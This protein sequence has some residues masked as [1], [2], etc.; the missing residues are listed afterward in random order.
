[1]SQHP[2]DQQEQGTFVGGSFGSDEEPDTTEQVDEDQDAPL[3]GA[4]EAPAEVEE[5]VTEPSGEADFAVDV[6]G[7]ATE[8][9]PGD[10]NEPV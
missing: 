10:R 4:G 5:Q 9:A 6:E 7:I 8:Q 2:D 3:A 1:M